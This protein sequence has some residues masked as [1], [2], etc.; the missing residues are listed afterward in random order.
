MF[1]LKSS[2]AYEKTA[3]EKTAHEKTA[4][5]KTAQASKQAGCC[6]GTAIAV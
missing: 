5:E 3:Y 4:Y 1:F 6:T 2:E